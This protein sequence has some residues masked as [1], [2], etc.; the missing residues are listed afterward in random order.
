[1][2]YNTRWRGHGP[3]STTQRS[4]TLRHFWCACRYTLANIKILSDDSFHILNRYI[5]LHI[6]VG[7]KM[8]EAAED[9]AG[10]AAQENPPGLLHYPVPCLSI[11]LM[12]QHTTQQKQNTDPPPTPAAA[13]A[14]PEPFYY[15]SNGDLQFPALES[16]HKSFLDRGMSHIWAC[17]RCT[18]RN[19]NESR[20]CGGV[21]CKHRRCE[22]KCRWFLI[23]GPVVAVAQKQ[24]AGK[25]PPPPTVGASPS[26]SKRVG[27]RGRDL[28]GAGG[29]LP[30]PPSDSPSSSK[31]V[32][33]RGRG[34]ERDAGQ[35]PTPP[36]EVVSRE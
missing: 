12:Q 14:P 11:P 2:L 30:T 3:F 6:I 27:G 26:S 10:S 29:Q 16:S 20:K 32:G 15:D 25:G 1:M 28:E 9:L 18:S 4:R 24:N 19:I 17:C 35:L 34:I 36:S 5:I 22:S 8:N 7:N 31:R 23:K 21:G 13:T 33:G